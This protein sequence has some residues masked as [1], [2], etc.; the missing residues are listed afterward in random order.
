GRFQKQREFLQ[1]RGFLLDLNAGDL[2]EELAGSVRGSVRGIEQDIGGI[3]RPELQPVTAL[4]FLPLDA[5]AV[6][7]SAVLAAQVLQN[8]VEALL[9]DLGVVAGNA[10]PSRGQSCCNRLLSRRALPQVPRSGAPCVE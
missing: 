6:Y 1:I 8:K 3:T 7:E 2:A 10:R 9:Q 4:Q 5:F